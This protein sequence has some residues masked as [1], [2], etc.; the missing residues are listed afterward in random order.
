MLL[1]HRTTI[2]LTVKQRNGSLGLGIDEILSECPLLNGAWKCQSPKDLGHTGKS[3]SSSECR[4]VVAH[5][6]N[7]STWE[8]EAGGFLSSRP[9]WS[10]E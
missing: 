9:A 2:R 7:P 5:D 4:A 3:R 6:F 10:T 1:F 8:A